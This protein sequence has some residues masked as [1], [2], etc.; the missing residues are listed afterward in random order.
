MMKPGSPVP[1]CPRC[2]PFGSPPWI[3]N[4]LMMRWNVVPSY[5]GFVTQLPFQSFHCFVP[6]A[7]PTKFA[8]VFGALSSKSRQES[9]PAGVS[10]VATSAP[11]PPMSGPFAGAGVADVLSG[12]IAGSSAVPA[13]MGTVVGGAL[14]GFC[15]AQES[16]RRH[17]TVRAMRRIAKA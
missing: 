10:S 2:G 11:G 9:A 3:M 13:A 8:T 5:A 16:G 12:A 17:T 15:E 7:R 4:P 1:G 14:A 6:C